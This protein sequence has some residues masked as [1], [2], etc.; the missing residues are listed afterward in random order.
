M[1]TDSAP[2]ESQGV[3]P[4]LTQLRI[5]YAIAQAQNTCQNQGTTSRA[6]ELTWDH[7]LTLQV[8]QFHE[9]QQEERFRH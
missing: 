7:A 2:L 6:C 4:A 5:R 9:V 1:N 3:S 8:A